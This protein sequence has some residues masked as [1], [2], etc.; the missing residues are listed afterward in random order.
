MKDG[1]NMG[2]KPKKKKFKRHQKI[3]FIRVRT[4]VYRSS[5]I[6]PYSPA[7]EILDISIDVV[8]IQS[9]P[10]KASLKVSC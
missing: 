3:L 8:P 4:L 1:P 5:S 6:L 7:P 10:V 9:S 2:R